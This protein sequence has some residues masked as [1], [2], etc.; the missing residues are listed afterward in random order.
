MKKLLALSLVLT[1]C[2]PSQNSE[3]KWAHLPAD[4]SWGTI[5]ALVGYLDLG[6]RTNFQALNVCLQGS[7]SFQGSALLLEAKLSYAAWLNAGGQGQSAF[8]RFQFEL[9][10][11]CDPSDTRYASVVLI[12]SA[13]KSSPNRNPGEDFSKATVNCQKSGWS[14]RCSS[15]STTYGWGGPAAIG[16]SYRNPNKWESISN[17]SPATVRLSPYVQWRS[18]ETDLVEQTGL[19]AEDRVAKLE[20]YRNLTAKA[21]TVSYA[22]LIDFMKILHDAKLVAGKDGSFQKLMQDFQRGGA[23]SINQEY[24]P[25]ATALHVLLHEVGHQF[26][27]SHADNPSRD[28]E[29]GFVVESEQRGS[30]WVTKEASM[31]Y[32]EPFLYLTADDEAGVKDM[33]Q[34]ALGLLSSR[35]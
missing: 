31:A 27:M 25:Y 23:S 13:G 32:G 12:E 16:Y 8:D 1:A 9:K 5:P 15:G 6:F 10:D 26:G 30:Q 3:T 22:E 24:T 19:A 17:R 34:K 11:I 33:T 21:D 2:G 29:T 18:L 4:Q 14:V 20:I 28:S 35:R 7:D